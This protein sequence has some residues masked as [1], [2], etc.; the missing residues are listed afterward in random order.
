LRHLILIFLSIVALSLFSTSFLA[1]PGSGIGVDR[2]GQI[3]FLDTGSGLWKI[4]TKGGL[5]HLSTLR[6]HWMAIDA[7]NG[8]AD[9]R[10]PTG[11]WVLTKVGSNPTVLISTDFPIAIG[12]DGNLYYPRRSAQLQIVRVT[13]SGNSSLFA[14]L[15]NKTTGAPLDWING[16]TAAPDDSIY[17]TEDN[18]VRRIDARGQTSTLATVPALVDGPSI[19]GTDQHPYLRGLSVDAKGVIYVADNGDA[20]VL[21]ITP[22]GRI[23]T[24]LQ[25][26]NGVWSPTAV[27]VYRDDLYVLEFSH[28]AGDDRTTW[29]PR[30]RKITSAGTSTIILTVDQMPGARPKPVSKVKGLGI[31]FLTYEFVNPFLVFSGSD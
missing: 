25:L 31:D 16:I 18:A 15:P 27:A 3:F 7:G 4:D 12:Q 19:P 30:I 1:H 17:Y 10:L 20:R 2:T 24:V 22:A 28:D 13:P 5:T 8:F 11:D 23:T 21:K 26:P 14:T 9:A 6:H 29:M